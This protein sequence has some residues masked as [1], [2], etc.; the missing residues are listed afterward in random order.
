MLDLSKTPLVE[1]NWLAAHLSDP[2]LRVVDA[3]WRGDGTSSRKLYEVG[4][5]PGAVPLDWQFDLAHTDEKG[6]RY[7]LLP[8]DQFAQKLSQAGIGNATQVV[9]Y[10]DYDY[11][12]ATRL[13]WALRYFGHS[14]VAVLNG[15]Y[16]KWL[17]EARPVAVE[18]DHDPANDDRPAPVAFECRIQPGWKADLGQIRQALQ[19][20]DPLVKLVDTRPPEQYAGR[21]VW[22]PPGS[23]YLPPVAHIGQPSDTNPPDEAKVDIGARNLMRSGHIPGAINLTSSTNLVPGEWT[24]LA[25]EILRQKALAAGLS[26]NHHIITY[27]GVGISASLGLFALHLAGYP[28]LAL[29]DASWEEWGTEPNLPVEY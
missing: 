10:A 3:R 23:F 18:P 22:T 21:A 28:N 19:A 4:H 17:A 5:I 25:P 27:C 7:M 16:N 12:G 11:S 8:P 20:R 24:F 15:G 1:T 6:L 26:P 13:W 2:T 14:Q 29:Y 9:A